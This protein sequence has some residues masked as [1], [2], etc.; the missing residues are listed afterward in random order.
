MNRRGFISV[1][2]ATVGSAVLTAL[3]C[4]P[5]PLADAPPIGESGEMLAS[6]Y[7]YTPYTPHHISGPEFIVD[8]S[9][10][11]GLGYFPSDPEVSTEC[12]KCGW[13]GK[14]EDLDHSH[15]G[16][17]ELARFCPSCKAEFDSLPDDLLVPATELYAKSVGKMNPSEHREALKEYYL[18]YRM[19]FG[20]EG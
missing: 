16:G 9:V 17:N 2:V 7:I 13:G 19:L 8:D 14:L 11:G 3:G 15:C 6:D 12:R 10:V 18:K 4:E 1:I 5:K 20:R